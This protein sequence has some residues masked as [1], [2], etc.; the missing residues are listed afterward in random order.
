MHVTEDVSRRGGEKGQR[1]QLSLGSVFIFSLRC[2]LQAGCELRFGDRRRGTAGRTQVLSDAE[3]KLVILRGL[4][5]GS[6]KSTVLSCPELQPEQVPVI[7]TC[8][9]LLPQGAGFPAPSTI[10][11]QPK[12]FSVAFSPFLLPSLSSE[13]GEEEEKGSPQKKAKTA[14]Q[15]HLVLEIISMKNCPADMRSGSR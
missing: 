13:N 9:P 3:G 5:R 8:K 12:F 14:L 1:P 10:R 7:H 11:A 6:K 2:V 4:P 15:S